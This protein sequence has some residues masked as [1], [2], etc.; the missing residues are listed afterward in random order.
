MGESTGK[1]EGEGY[2]NW[3]YKLVRSVFLKMAPAV[4]NGS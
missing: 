4:V 2:K 3:E 1:Q